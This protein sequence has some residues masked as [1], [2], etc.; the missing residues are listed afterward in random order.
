M[1]NIEDLQKLVFD[2]DNRA[3]YNDFETNVLP[4]IKKYLKQNIAYTIQNG[5][6]L[7]IILFLEPDKKD[8]S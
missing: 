6:L 3:D 5:R 4:K 1:E 8:A 7:T 2:F